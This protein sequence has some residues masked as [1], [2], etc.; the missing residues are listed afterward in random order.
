MIFIKKLIQITITILQTE[1]EQNGYIELF[2]DSGTGTMSTVPLVKLFGTDDE[3]GSSYVYSYQFYLNQPEIWLFE[4]V[5]YDAV[6]N[7]G[8][9]CSDVSVDVTDMI[10]KQTGDLY[11]VSY[12]DT[13]L[14][15]GVN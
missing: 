3:Y 7:T 6:G 4:Y 1:M 5:P 12:A 2:T 15:L 10:P 8:T 13:T 11:F 14:T 9:A